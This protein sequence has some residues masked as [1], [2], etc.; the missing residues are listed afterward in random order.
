MQ[1]P[2][3]FFLSTCAVCVAM[4]AAFYIHPQIFVTIAEVTF[5]FLKAAVD[6]AF[7][8]IGKTLL[9]GVGTG[10]HGVAETM[11]GATAELWHALQAT[12][13]A[14]REAAITLWAAS[15]MKNLVTLLTLSHVFAWFPQIIHAVAT[16]TRA[17]HAK[18]SYHR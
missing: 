3:A 17:R 6:S 12:G 10:L 8:D 13:L 2:T 9:V 15:S 7:N 18:S 16:M 1:A 14:C 4:W 5:T 11:V